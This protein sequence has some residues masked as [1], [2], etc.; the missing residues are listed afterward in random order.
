MKVTFHSSIHHIGY[1]N[2]VSIYESRQYAQSLHFLENKNSALP[3]NY[4]EVP[5]KSAVL[6]I[7]RLYSSSWGD[8]RGPPCLWIIRIYRCI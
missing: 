3:I 7:C 5:F 1:W 2:H 4:F 6:E 8:V